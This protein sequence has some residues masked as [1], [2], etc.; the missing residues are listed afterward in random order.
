MELQING[1]LQSFEPMKSFCAAYGLPADF[2]MVLFQPK[3]DTG[4]G[5]IDEAHVQLASLHQEILA[6][7]PHQRPPER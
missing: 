3:N 2:G 4:L 6:A 1:Q 7:T 5:R